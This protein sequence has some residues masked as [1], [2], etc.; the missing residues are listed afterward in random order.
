MVATNLSG[1]HQGP[2][3]RDL[4]S[5]VSHHQA[6]LMKMSITFIAVLGNEAEQQKSR[7]PQPGNGQSSQKSVVS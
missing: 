1:S 4:S 6:H 5:A 7:L 2:L 3:R